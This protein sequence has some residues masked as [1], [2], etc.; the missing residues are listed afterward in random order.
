MDGFQFIDEKWIGWTILKWIEC[1]IIVITLISSLGGGGVS[2]TGWG[3]NLLMFIYKLRFKWC[4][5]DMMPP[6]KISQNMHK[7]C[8]WIAHMS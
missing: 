4:V 7:L 2:Q 6:W 3:G 8:A 1:L 5:L